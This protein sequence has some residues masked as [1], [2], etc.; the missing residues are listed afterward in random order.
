MWHLFL[1]ILTPRSLKSIDKFQTYGYFIAWG[2]NFTN[3]SSVFIP[4]NNMLHFLIKTGNTIKYASMEKVDKTFFM[5]QVTQ[6]HE[7]GKKYSTAERINIYIQHP[8]E[9]W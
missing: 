9:F 7:T 5:M 6:K 2:W 4:K 8:S 1:H 3:D